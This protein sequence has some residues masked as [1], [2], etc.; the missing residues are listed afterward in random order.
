[1]SRRTLF[2]L[3]AAAAALT[4]PALAAQALEQPPAPGPLRPFALPTPQEFR[5]QNGV[6]VVVVEDH[7]LPMVHGRVLVNAG[8]VF[9]PA[10]KSGLALLTAQLLREGT[11][12][13]SGT[14]IAE[15]MEALGAQFGTG[16]G[17]TFATAQVTALRGAFPEAL[18]LAAT[19][20]TEPVFPEGE[21]GRVRNQ[22]VAA[23]QQ[24]VARV[25]GLAS[26]AF[27]RAVYDT[28]SG[29]ARPVGGTRATLSGI[30]R[31]DVV[32]YHGR[33]YGPANATLLLVGDVTPAEARTIAQQA[34][35]G[36]TA[37]TVRARA[38]PRPAPRA[39]TGNRV[40]LLDRPGSVQSGVF[41]GQAIPGADD[42][43][44]IPLQALT[45]VLGGGFRAR[46]NMLLREAR[47]WTYGAFAGLSPVPG[48]GDF[49]VTSSVRT[50]AT[51][52][53]VAAVV[54][55]V[56]RIAAQ[57]VPEAELRGSLANLVGSFPN[58]VQTV[59]GLAG[60][61]QTVLQNGY[62]LTYYSTYREQLA[63]VTPAD[64]ARVAGSRLTPD[65][66]T[67]VV[68]GD[69]ATI[70]QPIRALNLGAVEVWDA[71]GRKVR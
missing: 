70:E 39:A 71:E 10:E 29:Y 11:R 62:P 35:G 24:N 6:R 52:S 54:A 69:L 22:M 12:T 66:L 43:E 17:Q 65:A 50:N 14:Q 55:E 23:Y 9:E 33:M 32:R 59:Q 49:A 3:A 63:A 21:F 37:P 60:R 31:E 61:I 4:A 28:A 19:T 67:I 56:R 51:D 15:R 30:T 44:L 2:S 20:L 38:F 46:I 42:P 18:A 25:E 7:G 57:P 27:N 26:M 45:Q 58:S 68:A 16:A 47:G 13:R 8:S 1:M 41:V 40:I 34:L 64:L 48:A 53:A 5:L 36:W